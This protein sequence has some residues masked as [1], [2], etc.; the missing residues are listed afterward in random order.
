MDRQLDQRGLPTTQPDLKNLAGQPAAISASPFDTRVSGYAPTAPQAS[1]S[2]Q[3]DR[4]G[5]PAYVPTPPPSQSYAGAAMTSTS[6]A[7]QAAA[8]DFA[9]P[10]LEQGSRTLR[11]K[12]KRNDRQPNAVS[13]IS[14]ACS[15]PKESRCPAWALAER[16]H[17]MW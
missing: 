10:A 16:K 3:N 8:D 1:V 7:R 14:Q 5:W 13:S 11:L 6:H 15:N 2:E 12:R 17:E 9:N 4:S